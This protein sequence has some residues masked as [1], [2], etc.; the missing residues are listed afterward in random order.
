MKK[1]YFIKTFLGILFFTF[2]ISLQAI[3]SAVY[4]V[5]PP[6]VEVRN[7]SGSLIGNYFRWTLPRLMIN[8]NKVKL[9]Y[10]SGGEYWQELTNNFYVVKIRFYTP[11]DQDRKNYLTPNKVIITQGSSPVPLGGFECPPDPYDSSK[12]TFNM[13]A[14][15]SQQ[16]TYNTG[17]GMTLTRFH[18][19]QINNE[20]FAIYAEFNPMPTHMN[21]RQFNAFI[22]FETFTRVS[23]VNDLSAIQMSPPVIDLGQMLAGT[24]KQASFFV[25]NVGFGPTRF[26]PPVLIDAKTKTPPTDA[27]MIGAPPPATIILAMGQKYKLNDVEVTASAAPNNRNIFLQV[28]S[29]Y[30]KLSNGK[31]SPL[32]LAQ[33]GINYTSVKAFVPELRAW[34]LELDYYVDN[35]SMSNNQFFDLA[36]S[37]VIHLDNRSGA[38]SLLKINGV[39]ITGPN[40]SSFTIEAPNPYF[41]ASQT[42]ELKVLWTPPPLVRGQLIQQTATLEIMSNSIDTDSSHRGVIHVQLNGYLDGRTAGFT[43]PIN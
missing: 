36:T 21:P 33:T 42:D 28:S 20:P 34:P 32:P 18:S 25:E 8:N 1:L 13:M 10:A 12:T 24:K 9:Q 26:K 30:Q 3:S 37:K 7:T 22:E 16:V 5:N 14:C 19:D 11:G 27:Q 41:R 38:S 2:A 40:A 43:G 35:S 17:G 23:G 31:W 29:D 4:Q 39:N 15:I 6:M